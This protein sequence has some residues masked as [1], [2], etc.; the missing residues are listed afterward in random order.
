MTSEPSIGNP[1]KTEMSLKVMD[2]GPKGKI[3]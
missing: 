2:A 3:N 1:V